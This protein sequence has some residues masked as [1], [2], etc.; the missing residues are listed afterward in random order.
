MA[1]E[2]VV[3]QTVDGD[4]QQDTHTERDVDST[5]RA[6]MVHH[7]HTSGTGS[8]AREPLPPEAASHQVVMGDIPLEPPGFQSRAD[9]LAELDRADARVA[10]IHGATGLPGLGTTQLAAEYARAKLAADW[11]LVAWVNAA[12]TGS[13]EAGLATVAEAAG[14]TDG[15]SGRDAADAGSVSPMAS[16]TA[17]SPACRLSASVALTQATSRQSA[18]SLARAYAAASCEVPRPRNPVAA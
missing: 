8:R 3:D 10:V 6:L 15:G 9:L 14:L 12:E 13:L 4:V 1:R 16:A 7:Q 2:R 11:R 18:A 5:T 17:A